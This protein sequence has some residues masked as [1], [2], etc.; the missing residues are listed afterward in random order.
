[1]NSDVVES[2]NLT[3]KVRGLGHQLY[4]SLS[5]S[6]TCSNL[7]TRIEEET[8]LPPPYQRVIIR[9]MSA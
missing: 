9:G 3:I 4:I 7:Q 2:K 8:G 1:M 5:P 6:S